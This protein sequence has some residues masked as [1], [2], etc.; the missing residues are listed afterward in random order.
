M[1]DDVLKSPIEYLKGVGP[2]RAQLLQKELGIFTFDDLLHH[3][4]FRYVDRS[5]IYPIGSVKNTESYVQI[6]GK[7]TSIRRVGGV[8]LKRLSATLEDETGQMELVWFKS[9]RWISDS[10]KRR[11]HIS[12][13]WQTKQ[14]QSAA[15]YCSS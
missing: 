4:P 12:G 1:T 3:Y 14:V 5:I 15:K 13:I 6:F 9:L 10:I 8:R 7:I 2:K 11:P